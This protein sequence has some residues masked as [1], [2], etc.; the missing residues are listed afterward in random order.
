MKTAKRFEA[1]TA[2]KNERRERIRR[3]RRRSMD[4]RR[5]M[6]TGREAGGR[7]YINPYNSSV[8]QL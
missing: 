5:A 3:E 8:V 4:L 6:Y 2:R 7:C 1:E